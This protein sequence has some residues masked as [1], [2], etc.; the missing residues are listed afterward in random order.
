MA[1][2]TRLYDLFIVISTTVDE[3]RAAKVLTDTQAQIAN[4]G[5]AVERDDDW[6]ARP[7][8][9]EIN[10]QGEGHCRTTCGS[11]TPC[12]V[13]ASSATFPAPPRC[14][15]LRRSPRAKPRRRPSSPDL[16]TCG[17]VGVSFSSADAV[18]R[19]IWVT[20]V[21]NVCP[22]CEDFADFP[23]RRIHAV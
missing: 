10:H 14:R 8:A 6:H 9:Y 23:G 15:T 2:K 16:R 12:C 7:L 19:D 5:G 11:T 21:T 4:G 22:G 3:E 17:R 20:I 13:T 18:R 1:S